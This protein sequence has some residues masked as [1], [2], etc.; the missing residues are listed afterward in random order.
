MRSI[1]YKLMLQKHKN[2]ENN[3]MTRRLVLYKC[4]FMQAM[5]ACII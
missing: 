3:D 2:N 1:T 5:F 4:V